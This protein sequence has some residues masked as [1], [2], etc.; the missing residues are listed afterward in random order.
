MAITSPTP[1]ASN[2]FFAALKSRAAEIEDRHLGLSPNSAAL[3]SRAE[4]LYPG[5]YTRDAVIRTPHPLFIERG[6]GSVMVDCDGRRL[7]DFWLNATSL[8]LGHADPR[9]VEAVREQVAYGSSFFAPS[10]PELDL[11]ELLTAR[12]PSAERVRFTNSGSEAVMI[13]LRI[14]R[15]YTDRMMVVKFE[16]SYHGI[17]DDVYWSIS[18]P[19]DRFGPADNPT[20]VPYSAGLPFNS[21]RLLVLPFNNPSTVR[22]AFEEHGEEIAAVI[23]EPMANRIGL[24]LPDG[25]FLDAV[26]Q[27]CDT[28]G[29]VLIFD[30]VIAFRL[31]YH[32]AQGALGVTPDMTTLGKL[33]GGGFPVGGV[34]GRADILSVTKAGSDSSVTHSGTF[35]ANPVTM[36]AGRATMEALTPEAFEALNAKGEEIRRRLRRICDGLPLRVTGAGSL[37][38]VNATEVDIVDYRGTVTADREWER[39]ASLALLN[40]GIFLTPSLQGC[41]ATSTTDE[42]VERLLAA[43]ETLVTL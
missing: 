8:A 27:C 32:G 43:F 1:K 6:E 12:L 4:A 34:T 38:K 21:E 20:P 7:D 29:A 13:A 14:A 9:V 39:L 40:E 18:P 33:I 36:R 41:L 24:I 16:G 26:R 2:D 5:G 25:D 23:V 37:F 42:Q 28:S 22:R 10:R 3:F 31:G 11:A 19:A 30:E 15:A 17:Y 35:N